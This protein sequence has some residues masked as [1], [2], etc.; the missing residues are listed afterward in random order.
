MRYRLRQHGS[1]FEPI[2]A[3]IRKRSTSSSLWQ[4]CVEKSGQ[5]LRRNSVITCSRILTLWNTFGLV[6]KPTFTSRG[7]LTDK[8]CVSGALSIHI[9]FTNPL[10]MPKKSWCGVRFPRR[11][12]VGVSCLRIT[13]PERI[14]PWCSTPSSSL[15]WDGDDV[16]FMHSGSN[17]MELDLT[18]L[19]RSW[20]SYTPSSSISHSVQTFPTAI[21][22]RILIATM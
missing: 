12:W 18:L 15:N 17:R 4:L 2:Y 16:L 8:T 10:C 7:T 22:V 5:G 11:A 3:C 14:T 6:M 21:P 13:S 1:Y 9:K 20:N 19:Q